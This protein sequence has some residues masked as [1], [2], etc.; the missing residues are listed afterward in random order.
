MEGIIPKILTGGLSMAKEN[1]PVILT[2]FAVGGVILTAVLAA[3]AVPKAISI[4]EEEEEEREQEA[5]KR[6]NK[7]VEVLNK[8]YDE[9]Y[10][11][12]F[13]P[14]TKKDIFKLSW[15]YFV[16]AV[17]CG[18]LTIGCIVWSQHLNTVKQAALAASYEILRNSYD[19]YR[20]HV[21]ESIDKKKYD[22]IEQKIRED[23]V[24]R[25]LEERPLTQKDYDI[26]DAEA[27]AAVFVE[28]T[29]GHRFVSTYEKVYRAIDDVNE[30]LDS[31]R[32]SENFVTLA[33]L[34]IR[35]GDTNSYP[36]VA[37]NKGW[38]ARPFEKTI[39]RRHFLQPTI[40]EHKGHQCTLVYMSSDIEYLDDKVF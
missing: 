22:E 33:T 14:I 37:K 38:A 2:G 28:P 21:R 9:V 4:I 26:L 31:N 8:D 34:L 40:G 11:E 39:D 32:G 1:S 36:E 29:T 15:K 25:V 6:A 12:V 30:M 7:E 24:H 17:I 20:Y 13:K 19:D 35:A 5:D 16:P 27:G 18:S 23:R 10:D 3:R